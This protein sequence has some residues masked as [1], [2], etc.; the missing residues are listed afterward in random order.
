MSD[1]NLI[2]HTGTT[3]TKAMLSGTLNGATVDIAFVLHGWKF[4]Q[5]KY[6]SFALDVQQVVVLCPEQNDTVLPNQ[7][8]NVVTPPR[9]SSTYRPL[10]PV[11]PLNVNSPLSNTYPSGNMYASSN[12]NVPHS[13][14]SS[15]AEIWTRINKF[16]LATEPT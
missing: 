7:M 14:M 1:F 8:Y 4:G 5:E 2:N 16:W 3:I 10:T 15:S 9:R 11:T 13:P 6:W 12:G